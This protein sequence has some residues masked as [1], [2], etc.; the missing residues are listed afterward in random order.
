MLKKYN[1]NIIS[2]F[3]KAIAALWSGAAEYQIFVILAAIALLAILPLFKTELNDTTDVIFNI[4]IFCALAVAGFLLFRLKGSQMAAFTFAAALLLRLCLVFVLEYSTPYMTEE[5]RAR[6]GPWIKHYD[7]V[8]LQ[9]DE[10]FYIYQGQRYG[11]TTIGEFINSPEFTDN[12]HRAGFLASRLFEFFGNQTVWTRIVGAFLGAFAAAIIYLA[13]QKFFSKET[14]AIISLL[15]ALGPQTAFYSVRF[16]KEIWIIF[17]TSL[18][19]I[20]FAMII[21]N[22]RPLVAIIS[23]VTAIVILMWIRLEY[24]LM[25]IATVPI[26]ICYGYKSNPAGKTIAVLSLIFLGAI[27]FFYQFDRLTYK[28]ENMFD[29]YTLAER[30]QKGKPEAIEIVDKMYKSNGPLRILNIP[31]ALLNPL[32]KNLHHIYTQ[33]NKL[34]D[35]VLQANIYQ[36]WVLLPFLIIGAMVII[37]RRK[38]FLAF[39][40]PYLVAMSISALLLGGLHGDILRYRDSLAPIAFIIIG[41]GIEDFII[42][43][44]GWKNRIIISVYALFVVCAV[45]VLP[46]VYF[47]IRNF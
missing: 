22:R 11:D 2:R 36:W 21:R 32:P 17:A 42:S 1:D 46:I 5:V 3:F 14:S 41:V 39:L 28:A 25:F 23:I 37:T 31:F 15:A 43:S 8:L 12:A 40:L 34:Y 7:S 16:L 27:I 9:P 18:I 29:K 33:E 4:I 20:G 24:G 35:I 30:G 47:Y 19:I 38:E 26:A 13:A 10:F 6:S 44:K 45:A